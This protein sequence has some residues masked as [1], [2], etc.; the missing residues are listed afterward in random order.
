MQATLS[1]FDAMRHA[2]MEAVSVDEVLEIRDKAEALRAYYK[3]VNE[4]L[5]SQNRVAEIK[6]R[7]ERRIGELLA[8][9]PKNNGGRPKENHLHDERGLSL[10]DIGITH[11]Q[12]HRWQTMAAVPED[13]F[14]KIVSKV[15][16]SRAELTSKSIYQAGVIV[17]KASLRAESG[18]EHDGPVPEA[19]E[20][21]VEI[22]VLV[23]LIQQ[24]VSDLYRRCSINLR[25]VLAERLIS[26]GT[27]LKERGLLVC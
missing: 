17:K 12:S 2:I 5:D 20:E 22:D 27:E 8:E 25:P 21:P 24:A 7:A 6:I 4:G 15:L 18:V 11:A 1:R 13:E 26:V 16:D 9:M 23:D 19:L 14:C 10:A 3:Q